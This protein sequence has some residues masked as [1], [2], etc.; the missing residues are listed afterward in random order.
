MRRLRIGL[1]VAGVL[2]LLAGCDNPFAKKGASD[3]SQ[4]VD[5]RN[6]N[7]RPGGGVIVNANQAKKRTVALNDFDQL[8]T[9]IVALDLDNSRMPTAD[10]IKADL[11]ANPNARELLAKIDDGAIVL[12]GTTDRQGL[13]AYEVDADKAGGIV[14]AGGN[15]SRASADEVKQWLGQK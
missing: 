15:V 12:T 4:K 11:K 6:S 9:I 5:D 13:W 1:L 2:A 10:A 3:S 7:Y 8:K 14:L